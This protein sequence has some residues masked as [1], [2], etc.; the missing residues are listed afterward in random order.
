MYERQYSSNAPNFFSENLTAITMTFTW[1]IHTSFAIMML[2]FHKVSIIFNT[3][4]LT[5]S[6]TLY[7]NVVK[8]P[9]SSLEHITSDTTIL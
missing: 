5:L 9:D 6:K 2:F 8:F 4:L 7:T 3:L 1:M